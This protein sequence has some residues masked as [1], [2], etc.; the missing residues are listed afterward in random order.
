MAADKSFERILLATDGSSQ[1]DAAVEATIELARF[2]S[3][4][5]RVVH[6]WNLEVHHRHGF[7]D[8]E[9]RGEAEKLLQE[10][11]DRLSA[12]GVMADKEIYR[13]DSGHVAAAIALIAR[14]YEADLV[15]VG[16]RGLSDLQSVFQHSVSHQ[17]LAALDCPVLVVRGGPAGTVPPTRRI[18]VAIAGGEDV[19]PAVRA[20]VAAGRTRN[21]SVMVVHVAQAIF[22]VQGFAYVETDEEIKDTL[23][24][25]IAQLRDEGIAAESMILPSGSVARQIADLAM[26]WSADLIVVGSS[27]MG[28][29]TSMLLGSVSHELLRTVDIPVLIAERA[30][31]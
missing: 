23:K 19:S 21:S 8:V 29:V 7:W 22:G 10:T 4:V 17:V 28:D 5:V 31:R 9:V 12:A 27:R 25:A 30:Q 1:A 14:Q 13:A 26:T 6:I 16:S 18:L 24:R 2:S 11:V 15:V 3:A 20:A